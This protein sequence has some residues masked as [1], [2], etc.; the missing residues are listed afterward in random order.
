MPKW[1]IKQTA[2]SRSVA[3]VAWTGI[4]TTLMID[5]HTVHSLFKQ[6]V[7]V[8]ENSTCYL[9]PTSEHAEYMRRINLITS[10]VVH[11][12]YKDELSYAEVN[13]EV[14]VDVV[15]HIMQ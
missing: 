4:A 13:A 6:P 15:T 12:H 10:C 14:D 2:T 7:S 5:G 8:L 1:W 3:H 11:T 9:A